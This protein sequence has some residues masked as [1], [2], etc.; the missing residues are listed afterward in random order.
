MH[1]D[2]RQGAYVAK[3]GHIDY[4]NMKYDMKTAHRNRVFMGQFDHEFNNG[5][6]K[7]YSS[8]QFGQ[9][10]VNQN[11]WNWNNAIVNAF[12]P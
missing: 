9:G 2:E 8:V 3:K 12:K 10:R 4:A 11:F 1:F 6:G 5:F 7:G